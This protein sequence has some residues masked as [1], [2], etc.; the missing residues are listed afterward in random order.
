MHDAPVTELR[1]EVGDALRAVGT[2][3]DGG[4]DVHY[5]RDAVAEQLGEEGLDA[6]RENAVFD[7]LERDYYERIF[8]TAGRYEATVRQFE[9]AFV[10]EVPTDDAGPGGLLVSLDREYAGSIRDV[11]EVCRDATE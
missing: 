5:L 1:E 3:D 10:V 9:E 2:Y 7:S 8:A 11:I 6:I 4:Y